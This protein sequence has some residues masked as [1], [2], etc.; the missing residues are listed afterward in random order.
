MD[1]TTPATGTS[2]FRAWLD[3]VARLEQRLEATGHIAETAHALRVVRKTRARLA[4]LVED[5]AAE[6]SRRLMLT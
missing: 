5:E 1:V 3:D 4:Q 6:T 2:V